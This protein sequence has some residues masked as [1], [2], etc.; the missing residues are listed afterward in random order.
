M[1]TKDEIKEAAEEVVETA[2]E[3]VEKVEEA[4]EDVKEEVKEVKEEVEEKAE[5]VK[6]EV[7]ST[8]KTIVR[9]TAEGETKATKEE[10]K[11]NAKGLRITSIILWVVAIAVEVFCILLISKTLYVGNLTVALIIGIVVDAA[12]CVVAA[13]LWKKSNKIDPPKKKGNELGFFLQTQLGLIMAV[14]CLLPLIIVLLCNKEMDKKLKRIVTIIAIV[15]L[16]IA[17]A[18]S[19][20]YNPI[21]LEEKEAAEAIIDSEVYWTAFGKKYHTDSECQAL[22]NSNTL[23]AGDVDE[24][25][26]AGRESLCAFCARDLEAA[27]VD[28]SELKLTE[29]IAEAAE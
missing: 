12:L 11:G 8:G 29:E 26:E 23:Y 9:K 25:I 7:T 15:C 10:K 2:E 4:A 13:L 22:T 17:A 6:K 16:L 5:K 3:A 24:A 20:D 19:I 27:G 14:I 1:A 21:S 28:V 18:F